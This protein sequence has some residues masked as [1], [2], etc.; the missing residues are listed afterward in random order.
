MVEKKKVEEQVRSPS[1]GDQQQDEERQPGWIQ[2]YLDLADLLIRRRRPKSEDK[3]K[4][5]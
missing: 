1:G 5:A 2:K 3:D 4:A